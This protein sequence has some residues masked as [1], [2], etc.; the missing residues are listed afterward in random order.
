LRTSRKVLAAVAAAACVLLPLSACSSSS[1]SST[2]G[3]GANATADQITIWTSSNAFWDYQAKNLGPFEKE[4]GIKVNFV[5]I[6]DSSILDKEALAQRAKSS[7]FAM[8]EG[9]TSLLSQNVQLLGGVDLTPKINN[10]KL[11]DSSFDYADFGKGGVTDCTLKGTVYCLP[12]FVDGGVLGYNKKI[13]AQAG[14]TSAPTTWQQVIADADQV[15]AKTSVP[16]WCTRGSQAGAAIATAN[17]M[18]S[19][20]IP[21]SADNQG[22]FVGPKWNSLLDSSGA[23]SWANDYQHLMTKDAAAGI[24]T[25]T[26]TNCANDFDQGKVGMM[27]DGFAAFGTNELNPPAGSALAGNVDFA[28]PTCPTSDPC[29][30]T[31]PWGMYL[32][33]KATTAQQ[34]SAW[35][36]MQYLDSKSF[37]EKEIK[38]TGVPALAVRDSISDETFPGIPASFLT[39]E[40][41]VNAH[42]EPNPFPASSVFNESQNAYQISISNIVAGKPVK[43]QMENAAA[44]QN[45]VFKQAGLQK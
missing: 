13:F 33:P 14:I 12:V 22:F 10:T 44:G 43:Q 41:Y 11:T 20:Y 36:L 8:Y 45:K 3:S 42:S 39:A 34:N 19:Y 38:A 21:W 5:Q 30:A 9:P 27:W 23:L 7:E 37:I 24:G 15:T 28:E 32:N 26:Y 4:T 31:G 16:G 6:P 29:V 25:Y 35:K 40:K 17:Q 18:L 1:T 2:S